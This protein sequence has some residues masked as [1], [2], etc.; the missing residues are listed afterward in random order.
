MVHYI[1]HNT[2]KTNDKRRTT[3]SL[4]DIYNDILHNVDELNSFRGHLASIGDNVDIF[5]SNFLDSLELNSKPN[6]N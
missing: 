2:Y 3:I 5:P 4:S 1:I 6:E